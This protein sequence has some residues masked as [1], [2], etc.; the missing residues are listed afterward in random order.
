MLFKKSTEYAIKVLSLMAKDSQKQ[1]FGTKE[2]AESIQVS[3]TYLAKILQKLQHAG[4]VK[5]ITGPGG[6]FSLAK[7]AKS[8]QL[9]DI[10]KTLENEEL[11]TSCA[12]G[13]SECGTGN[14][15]P[16]HE[17]WALF[18]EDIKKYLENISVSDTAE[19]FWP[20]YNRM[21]PPL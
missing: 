1:F 12:L 13:M 11:F 20:A 2:L 8:I 17:K 15:C 18:R 21:P 4:F 5:S 3:V 10:I 9:I 14:P 7:D 16:L 6:G 19:D